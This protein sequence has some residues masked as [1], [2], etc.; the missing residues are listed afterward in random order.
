[1]T[2]YCRACGGVLDRKNGE[3]P[4][5][6]AEYLMLSSIPTWM[7]NLCV[8]CLMELEQPMNDEESDYIGPPTEKAVLK[9]LAEKL[10]EAARRAATGQSLIRCEAID[11]HWSTPDIQCRRYASRVRDGRHFCFHHW[12]AQ[13]RGKKLALVN[14]GHIG[15]RLIAFYAISADDARV[16][17]ENE[18]ARM[19][20]ACP[21][22]V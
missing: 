18:I 3:V 19:F 2:K 20:N 4:E 17:A 7:D 16:S 10:S 6:S 5:Q 22:A 11:W 12:K 14:S 13:E 8:G 9:H 15:P 21:P 1:M